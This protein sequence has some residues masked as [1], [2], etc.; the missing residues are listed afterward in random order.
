MSAPLNILLTQRG[1]QRSKPKPVPPPPSLSYQQL[2]LSHEPTAYWRMDDEDDPI[3]DMVGGYHGTAFGTPTYGAQ[4]ALSNDPSTAIS[5]DGAMEY[6]E[7]PHHVDLNPQSSE[8]AIEFWLKWSSTPSYG[9]VF[10]KFNFTSPFP[11]PTI[12][13]DYSNATASRSPGIISFRDSASAG[14]YINSASNS[15]NDG[16]YRHFV[17]QRVN[18][19][20]TWKLQLWINGTLDVQQNI[21]FIDL[22]NSNPIY[23]MGRPSGVQVV[24]GT[25]DELAYYNGKTL[26]PEQI[27]EHFETGRR[28]V[29]SLLHFNG[30]DGS[31]TFADEAGHSW[32]R[33]GSVVIDTDNYRFGGASAYFDGNGDDLNCTNSTGEFIPQR[34]RYTIE[35]WFYK[36][37]N[38]FMSRGGAFWSQTRNQGQGEQGLAVDNN[39]ALIL[40]RRSGV[41]GSTDSTV[42]TD[43][44][45]FTDDAWHHVAET[46]DGTYVRVYLDGIEVLTLTNSVGWYSTPEPFRIG[47]LYVPNFAN[48][49]RVWEGWIDEFRVT[50]GAVV[51][52]TEFT[53]PNAPLNLDV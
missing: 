48:F 23:I 24:N 32:T 36:S 18:D 12:F 20:G 46:F 21:S 13:V 1:I 8:Y 16:V 43:N 40:Y 27:V 31:T 41:T 28:G 25:I 34:I 49:Q 33:N 39:G 51:Y 44:G 4:G 53:P 19:G 10:G 11:G 6:M 29:M 47:R 9:I 37:G 2:I 30:T 38:G 5:F 42:Q 26:T 52:K 50:V 15:L 45:V 22:T 14:Y 35:G 7:V 3:F 17:C